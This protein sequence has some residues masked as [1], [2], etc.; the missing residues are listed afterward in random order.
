MHRILVGEAAQEA[1]SVLMHRIL[2]GETAQESV[3]S[4]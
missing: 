2:V 4:Q 1:V 3:L